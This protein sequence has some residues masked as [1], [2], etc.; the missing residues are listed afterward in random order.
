M[1][2]SLSTT[3][4]FVAWVS[5][6]TPLTLVSLAMTP[7]DGSVTL[8]A[9]PAIRPLYVSERATAVANVGAAGSAEPVT[10]MYASMPASRVTAL[11]DR[12]SARS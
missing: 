9:W 11:P 1:P 5:R 8:N 10:P 7:L 12:P 4:P 3:V 2:F 6:L